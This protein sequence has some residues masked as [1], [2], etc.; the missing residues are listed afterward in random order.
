MITV[1]EGLG[2]YGRRLASSR[3]EITHEEFVEGS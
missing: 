2:N 3:A 1:S